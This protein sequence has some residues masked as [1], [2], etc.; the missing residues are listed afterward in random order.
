MNFSSVT[1]LSQYLFQI[2]IEIRIYK[3][4]YKNGVFLFLAENG[5]TN[6]PGPCVDRMEVT[7]C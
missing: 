2:F 4:E 1:S 7:E 5:N 6:D 3:R